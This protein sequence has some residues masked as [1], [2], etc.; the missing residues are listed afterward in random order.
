MFNQRLKLDGNVN[1]MRQIVKN[2]PVSGGF[3]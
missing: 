3:T 2:K 1:V